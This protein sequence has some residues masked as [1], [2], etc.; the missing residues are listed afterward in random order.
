M[1]RILLLAVACATA[2]ASLSAQTSTFF[3][4]VSGHQQVPSVAS[5]AEARV[6]VRIKQDSIFVSSPDT[7]RLTSPVNPAIG[8]HIHTGYA[9]QNG[10]VVLPLPYR[11]IGTSSA[12]LRDTVLV[13]RQGLV[14]SIRAAA[15]AGR[16]YVNVHTLNY[17]A[18]EVRG[19]LVTPVVVAVAPAVQADFRFDA[20]LYGD[21]ENP[22]VLTE[23]MGGVA[24]E[25]RADSMFFTGAF[26][27]ESPLS[28]VGGTGAHIH[29]GYFGQNGGILLALRPT[30]AADG[31]S[32]TFER[33]RNAFVRDTAVLNPMRRRNAYVNIHSVAYPA[34]EIRGQ[35]VPLGTN[36]Y[37]SHV[38]YNE[39][40]AFP[41]ASA[42]LR[43]MAEKVPNANRVLYSGSWF[44]WR[45]EVRERKLRVLV[46][47]NNPFDATASNLLLPTA[48]LQADSSS[49]VVRLA[50]AATRTPA[51]LEGLF[52]RYS[53]SARWAVVTGTS[54][55]EF[56]YTGRHYHECKRAFYSNL[57]ASQV[58]PA[59]PTGGNGDITTEYYG[60]RVDITGFVGGLETPVEPSVTGGFHLR[61]GLAG[62][63][64]DDVAPVNY[65]RVGTAGT[66]VAILPDRAQINLTPELAE[67]MKERGFYYAIN[68][69][70]YFRGE[71]RG[72]VL[73]QSNTVYHSIVEP[74]QAVP[75]GVITDG[76]GAVMVEA[77]GTKMVA[78]GTF[79]ELTGFD[80][81]VAGGA[82][83]HA[84]MP[85]VTGG[86]KYGLRTAA[87]RGASAGEFLADDNSFATTALT[88]DSLT[89]RQFYVNIHTIKAPSG[90]IRGQVAPLANNVVHARL[91]PQVT[92]P[93]TGGLGSSLGRGN[94]QGEVY[95]TTVVMYGH[96]SGLS[97]AI[98]TLIAG[99]ANVHTG[100]VAEV[101]A[102]L[103]GL[104]MNLSAK[105]T[106]AAVLPRANVN[107]ILAVQR[108]GLLFG[109]LY[110]NVHTKTA[111]SG[112]IR[113]QVLLSENQYPDSVKTF[114]F[115]ADRAT[116]DLNSGNVRSEARVT[117][118][119]A[120]DPDPEQRVAYIWQLF[121]D[122]TAA[123][124]IQTTVDSANAV[125]FTF[126]A[127]DTL[128]KSLGLDSG[129]T[130]TVY[131]RA[132]TTDGSLL[133][134]GKI[135]TV[136]FK[137]LGMFVGVGELPQGSARLI[138]TV[139]ANG[140]RL[141]VAI[142][143]L[144]SGRYRYDVVNANG[145]IIHT[146]AID[147]G[148]SAQ[149]YELDTP[150][151]SAGMYFLRLSNERGEATAWGFLVQ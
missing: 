47:L 42:Y 111:S 116:V 34:G 54:I 73:P 126:G 147:H 39:P 89:N 96:F 151:A 33:S 16:T 51:Q 45:Q 43:V 103:F 5:Q 32:G 18:G 22:G 108:G 104:E 83:L 145:Q 61:D 105:D 53:A 20:M 7:M 14:D 19:Q 106:A 28:P 75:G 84:G 15:L 49:G 114:T 121:T 130:A 135:S 94:L 143:A 25:V 44:G 115:P 56:A 109:G 10:P 48:P 68:T 99:G 95:D 88:M 80:P 117:W 76:D 150:G 63:N 91:S 23:G 101:G 93:Y 3:A 55:S 37:P 1:K 4:Q 131:H 138:N 118:E 119:R 98:D 57:T 30:V 136:T 100:K 11:N 132:W 69:A 9:G 87:G 85:G 21:Q 71:L 50:G 2:S 77:Y 125:T 52:L 128:L 139:T 90:E 70:G 79:N 97:S 66:A 36:I 62:R 81:N 148:G 13:R 6:T 133:T 92:K 122:T 8:M 31:L 12:R 113:G 65:T 142:D 112:A 38:S 134:P 64:G 144:P 146:A 120:A 123:P 127:L 107:E 129:A 41:N 35:V 110:A 124:V 141:F 40:T 58:V 137:R 140:G 78:S 82:H 27:L 149:R 102:I 86:I 67:R 26:T 24:I 74:A 46:T 60:N 29:V 59:N 72:Q 17:P